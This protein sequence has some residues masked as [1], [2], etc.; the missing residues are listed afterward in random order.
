MVR[1][2]GGEQA[3]LPSG[4]A[5]GDDVTRGFGRGRPTVPVG[6]GGSVAEQL[7]VEGLR[8][9]RSCEEAK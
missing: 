8:A 4:D 6:R 9:T 1:Q 5:V 3:D 7:R 2:I